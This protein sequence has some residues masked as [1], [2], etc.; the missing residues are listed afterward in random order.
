ML[1]ILGTKY[2]RQYQELA[3][4]SRLRFRCYLVRCNV[5]GYKTT[6]PPLAEAAS[7]D[8]AMELRQELPLLA[9]QQSEITWTFC[10]MVDIS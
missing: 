4:Q 6:F 2:T 3:M 8:D 1:N 7:C 5:H 9:N 10:P